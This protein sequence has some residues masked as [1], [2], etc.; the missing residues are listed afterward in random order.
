METNQAQ[1]LNTQATSNVGLPNLRFGD[2]GDAVRVLQ[3]LLINNRYAIKV[4]GVFGALTETAVKAFQ[5]QRNL[6]ADG[7]VGQ[8]T[9]RELAN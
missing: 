9:W 4:D 3:R 2:A 8:R 6:K 7:I 5:S 1:P